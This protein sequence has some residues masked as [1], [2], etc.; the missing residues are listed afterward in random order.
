MNAQ[1]GI[2][3]FGFFTSI[4]ICRELYRDAYFICKNLKI[5]DKQHGLQK[6]N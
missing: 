1:K 2:Y 5:Y 6:S 4:N 3:F